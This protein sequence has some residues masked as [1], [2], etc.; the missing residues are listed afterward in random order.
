MLKGF[1]LLKSHDQDL[2]LELIFEIRKQNTLEESEETETGPKE[3]N[4]A[5]SKLTE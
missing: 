2:M 5:V 1:K 3:R 4:M